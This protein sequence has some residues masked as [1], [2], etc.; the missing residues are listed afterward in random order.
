MNIAVHD[1]EW[2]PLCHRFR[3][4]RRCHFAPAGPIKDARSIKGIQASSPTY[5]HWMKPSIRIQGDRCASSAVGAI[6]SSGAHQRFR[7]RNQMDPYGIASILPLD[8]TVLN[9]KHDFRLSPAAPS[10][11][12]SALCAGQTEAKA[13]SRS[14]K[15]HRPNIAIE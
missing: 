15:G 1:S 11:H 13:K 6:E 5:C 12:P 3:R 2:S 7:G 14:S 4:R 8:E 9:P 10:F